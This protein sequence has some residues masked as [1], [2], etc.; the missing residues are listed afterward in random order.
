MMY[1]FSL[2]VNVDLGYFDQIILCGILDKAVKSLN[3]EL[4][5][6]KLDEAKVKVKFLRHF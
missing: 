6:E 2:N 3:V 1:S 4:G 5:I